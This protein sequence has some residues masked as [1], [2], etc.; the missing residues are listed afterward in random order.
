MVKCGRVVVDT[1]ERKA[2]AVLSPQEMTVGSQQSSQLPINSLQILSKYNQISDEQSN[3]FIERRKVLHVVYR[4]QT[5]RL[6]DVSKQV[7]F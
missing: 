3:Y 1:N 6:N 4:K 5:V 7:G 2:T